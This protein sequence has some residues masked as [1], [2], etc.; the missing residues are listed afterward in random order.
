MPYQGRPND[1]VIEIVKTLG[2][3]IWTEC[4]DTVAGGAALARTQIENH[5]VP[6]KA[7]T[8]LGWRPIEFPTAQAVAES[9][10]SVFDLSGPNYNYQPQ[11]VMCGNI[12]PS[13][14]A[15]GTTMQAP[16]EYY[17][18]FA[19]VAGGE[20]ISVGIEPLDAIAGN[21]RALAEF[22]WTDVRVPLPVIRS[23]CSREVALAIAAVGITPGTL[24]SITDAHEL[25]EAGGAVTPSTNT[26]QEEIMVTLILKCTALP[27]NEIRLGFE[28]CGAAGITPGSSATAVTR[29]LQRMKFSQTACNV[30]ADFDQDV[31]LAVAAQ[32]GHY[33]RWI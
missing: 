28:P 12:A 33:I 9:T 11:E 23:F 13:I 3:N 2:G 18:V 29:R 10:F 6:D 8:L 5:Q 1:R 30:T 24:L 14:L 22:T 31:A 4:T 25:I 16:S 20:Q 7:K 17:D 32:A 26:V 27:V 21:R 19:P 15:A